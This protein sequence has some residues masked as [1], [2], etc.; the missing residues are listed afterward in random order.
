MRESM[1]F[2]LNQG[3]LSFSLSLKKKRRGG[4]DTRKQGRGLVKKGKA[5]EGNL[6]S[7]SLLRSRKGNGVNT[8]FLKFR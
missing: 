7:S 8:P 1:D 5:R 6:T 3:D 2:E 4:R